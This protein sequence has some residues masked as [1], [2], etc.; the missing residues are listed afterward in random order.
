M[1]SR[2]RYFDIARGVALLCVILSHSILF[3]NT[4]TPMG[5]IAAYIYH[6]CFSFHMPLFLMLSGYFMHPERP[7]NW[8]KESREL[9]SSYAITSLAIIVLNMLLAAFQHTDIKS[10]FANW[11]AAAFY[12]A[13]AMADNYLW[14]VPLRI[15]A[16]WFLL[17]LF[18][19]H[20]FIHWAHRQKHPALWIVALFIIGYGT[21]NIFWLPLSLQSG[22]TACSFVYLG[23][24]MKQKDILSKLNNHAYLWFILFTVWIIFIKRFSGF[25]VA[26]NQ[27]GETPVLA[28]VGSI[29][30]SL[31]I[32]GLSMLID[33]HLPYINAMLS[34][35]GRHTLPLLCIHVI[36]DDVIPWNLVI[37]S[38]L[39]FNNGHGTSLIV[40]VIR[41]IIDCL[42][43][44]GLYFIPH[45]NKIFFPELGKQTNQKLKTVSPTI[46]QA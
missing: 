31:C 9:L 2:I 28:Y 41:I 7:F 29:C 26:L 23:Y 32:L 13:G 27:Y 12:G 5:T 20:L 33:K 8:N 6:I 15:G 35:L 39:S 38:L 36:E 30:G 34:N 46:A 18:W 17:A 37:H 14:P 3:V 4:V 25:S 44:W 16:I 40:F 43:A 21:S 42:L 1:S 24:L 19:S 10:A 45:I 22:M 11:T